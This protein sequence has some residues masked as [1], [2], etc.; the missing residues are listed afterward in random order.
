MPGSG[1]ARG[2]AIETAGHEL[3]GP[4]GGRMVSRELWWMGR[5]F[6]A[7]WLGMVLVMRR[8]SLEMELDKPM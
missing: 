5:S 3:S 4:C 1:M 2:A 6:V 8:P 7:C